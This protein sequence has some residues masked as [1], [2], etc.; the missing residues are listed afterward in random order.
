MKVLPD[1]RMFGPQALLLEWPA[2][3]KLSTH[4]RV[5]RCAIAIETKFVN[6]ILEVVPTYHS[7]AIYLKAQEDLTTFIEKLKLVL[8]NGSEE[9]SK[10]PQIITVPVCYHSKFALDLEEISTSL[11]ISIPE[12][13]ELHTKP[14]YKVYFLGFLPGFPYL[15]RLDPRLNIP[16]RRAPR[17]WVEQGSVAI[18]GKQTGLYSM[19][20]PGGWNIIGKT[21]LRLFDPNK[22]NP[23][24][25]NAGDLVKFEPITRTEFDLIRVEVES[26]TFRWRKEAVDD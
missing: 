13:I 26:E 22:S 7:L 15:G 17:P 18:G 4:E 16:R 2:E 8:N 25:I 3:I 12:I 19:D 10:H 24:Q 21:P 14:L 9:I 6:Q 1:I 11:Q 20:S 5:M 23:T